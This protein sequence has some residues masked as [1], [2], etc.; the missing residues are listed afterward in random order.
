M[1][2]CPTGSRMATRL[3]QCRPRRRL[4]DPGAV[5]RRASVCRRTAITSPGRQARRGSSGMPSPARSLLRP[6]SAA[7]RVPRTQ[8]VTACQGRTAAGR[9]SGVASSRSLTSR[10]SHPATTPPTARATA[11]SGRPSRCRAS[12]VRP[13]R[14]CPSSPRSAD[15]ADSKDS[16]ADTAARACA[17]SL[18]ESAMLPPSH[19]PGRGVRPGWSPPQGATSGRR[20]TS[21]SA[22]STQA[23]M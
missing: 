1:T 22:C 21:S 10:T 18:R 2:V 3:E 4:I 11:S 14:S 20:T 9:L 16:T 15:G 19:I 12:A 17:V 23:R 6:S 7:P 13:P 5:A 8:P